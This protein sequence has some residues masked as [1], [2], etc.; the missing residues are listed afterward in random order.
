MMNA[1]KTARAPKR[2]GPLL[3]TVQPLKSAFSGSDSSEMAPSTMPSCGMQ[4][5]SAITAMS[6]ALIGLISISS[7]SDRM[8]AYS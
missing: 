8:R 6:T 7:S 3:A 5:N 1:Q 2:A 4:I